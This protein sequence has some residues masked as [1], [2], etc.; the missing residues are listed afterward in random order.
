M[1]KLLVVDD[2]STF[3]GIICSKLKEEKYLVDDTGLLTIAKAMV[4]NNDYSCIICD[5]SLPDGSGIELKTFLNKLGKNIPIVFVTGYEVSSSMLLNMGI[6]AVTFLQKP[7]DLDTLR[8]AVDKAFKL[9]KNLNRYRGIPPIA[10]LLVRQGIIYCNSQPTKIINLSKTITIGRKTDD[11]LTDYAIDSRH[12]SRLQCTFVRT[13]AE[14]GNPHSKDGFSL[15][16]GEIYGR[17]S[18]NGS[19][20]N[21]KRIICADL[22][23]ADVI[24]LPTVSLE[25][26]DLFKG[27]EVDAKATLT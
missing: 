12:A 11:T 24:E 6:S 15:Y 14:E 20:V 13:F 10:R 5:V 7:I 17:P 26:I 16:D 4:V 19:F 2:D 21:G 23:Q 25:Y 22:K 9:N 18:G 1:V 3:R 8:A 27:M